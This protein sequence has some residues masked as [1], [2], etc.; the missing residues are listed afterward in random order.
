MYCPLPS[1]YR[2]K[3][4]P[5]RIGPTMRIPIDS[6]WEDIHTQIAESA[7]DVSI[8]IPTTPAAA[9]ALDQLVRAGE[10]QTD[11]MSPPKC[12]RSAFS[13]PSACAQRRRGASTP[14]ATRDRIKGKPEPSRPLLGCSASRRT[15]RHLRLEVLRL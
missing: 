10:V 2:G 15:L 5:S 7:S 14:T 4:H 13:G 1:S 6:G 11:Q 3:R 9:S 12:F 8:P